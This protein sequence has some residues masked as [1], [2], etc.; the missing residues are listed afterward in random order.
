MADTTYAHPSQFVVFSE[1]I[2]NLSLS[3][4][5]DMLF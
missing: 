3:R 2:Y 5:Q 4:V 1:L